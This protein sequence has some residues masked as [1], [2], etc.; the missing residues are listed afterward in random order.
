MK[1]LPS[2]DQAV[3]NFPAN[4]EDH[5]FQVS[6]NHIIQN[7][8]VAESQLELGEWVRS[9]SFDRSAEGRWLIL[10]PARDPGFDEALLPHGQRSELRFGLLS[11]RDVVGHE[12]MIKTPEEANKE[13][14]RP[15]LA[16]E[17]FSPSPVPLAAG[18]FVPETLSCPEVSDG[19]S[20]AAVSAPAARRNAD[21]RSN[22]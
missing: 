12:D 21:E 9:E 11:D 18:G 14:T 2:N 15:Y 8:Q 20:P 16:N 13:E 5:D 7:A 10:K 22:L 19:V 1:F 3:A 4:Q 6:L 17:R